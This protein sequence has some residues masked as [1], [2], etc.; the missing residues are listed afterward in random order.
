MNLYRRTLK[1]A[2]LA[3]GVSA[4][5]AGTPALAQQTEIQALRAQIEELQ[6]RLNK[7]ETDAA[8]TTSAV[9]SGAV[10][11]SKEK[12][13]VSG[14]LQVHGLGFLSEDVRAGG[15]R[16]NDTIRLRRGEL[17]LTAPSITPRVSGTIMFDPAKAVAGRTNIAN[18]TNLNIRARDNVLQE[19]QVSYLLSKIGD[20]KN[21]T[22]IDVG[23]YKIPIGYES[24]VSSGALQTVERALLFTQR[25]P[26]DGGYGDVRDSGI[27]VRGLLSGQ[28][29][30]RL[31]IFNGLGENQNAQAV[32]DQKAIIGR[33]AYLPTSLPGFQ[34]GVS[35][36]KAR[37]ATPANATRTDRDI[38]NGFVAYKRD[39][40]SAQ[41][42]YLSGEQ[43]LRGTA[44]TTKVRGYYASLGYL[45]TP[46]L[47]GVLRYDTFDT[48]RNANN[49]E[50]KDYTLG[51][52]YY[53]KG[54]NAKI[55]ANIVQ[56]DSDAGVSSGLRND[57]TEL[58]TNFQIA[59]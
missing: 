53:I 14:L 5:S 34:I 23:Q 8:K 19:I 3:V 11:Q 12:V 52:N 21:Q 7:I 1:A 15:T 6:T 29:D 25:D 28:L 26:F 4:L 13:T 31:G 58:R 2:T 42:E 46:K 44:I 38:L 22:F 56:R 57:R 40:F 39:K 32:S 43:Q 35:A 55:Q 54:N 48:N 33:L 50:V 59:F 17:R 45:F 9:G 37:N 49:A 47:E 30:Y 36:G 10:V 16:G 27:Q 18:G 24:L 41:A 51:L 20:A